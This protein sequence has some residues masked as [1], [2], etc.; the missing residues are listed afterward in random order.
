MSPK[1]V[2]N[3]S[4]KNLRVL[5]YSKLHKKIIRLLI[6]DTSDNFCHALLFYMTNG[7]VRLLQLC[8]IKI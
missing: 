4:L 5:I 1:G 8:W 7:D 2:C 6:N 3:L